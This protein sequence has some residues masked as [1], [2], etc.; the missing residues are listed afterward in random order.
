MLTNK[1]L[2]FALHQVQEI[3][4]K[5]LGEDIGI[6]IMTGRSTHDFVVNVDYGVDKMP[7]GELIPMEK[8]FEF[9]SSLTEDQCLDYLQD[10]EKLIKKQQ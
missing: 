2:E 5:K 6:T 8:E 1:Q 9:N 4:H 7:N 3:Q 10:I